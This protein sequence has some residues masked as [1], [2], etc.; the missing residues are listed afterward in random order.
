MLPYPSTSTPNAPWKRLYLAIL[1][2]CAPELLFSV[3][4]YTSNSDYSVVLG[5]ALLLAGPV[6]LPLL[7][8][9]L[10][11]LWRK[12]SAPHQRKVECAIAL[13]ITSVV[14]LAILLTVLKFKT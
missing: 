4:Y 2:M 12:T 13:V 10:R 7:W 8:L 11:K 1:I 14:Y 9:F 3:L 5:M 6:Q